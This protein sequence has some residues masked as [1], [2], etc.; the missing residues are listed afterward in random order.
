MKTTSDA[1]ARDRMIIAGPHAGKTLTE[2][3]AEETD[4]RLKWESVTT[5]FKITETVVRAGS[6]FQ[7]ERS[8]TIAEARAHFDSL[9]FRVGIAPE[10]WKVP[11][12][13]EIPAAH[14]FL[15][16]N[17]IEFFQGGKVQAE[18]GNHISRIKLRAPGYQC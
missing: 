9:M 4:K 12:W 6:V 14:V 2:L 13:V 1:N 17:S 7:E 18:A 15:S 16:M 5:A 8:V 3:A 11:F 10:N